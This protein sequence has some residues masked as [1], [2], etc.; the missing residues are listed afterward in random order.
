[1]KEVKKIFLTDEESELIKK[2]LRERLR[3]LMSAMGDVAKECDTIQNI[4]NKLR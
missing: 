2:H 4:I 1:M 3:S